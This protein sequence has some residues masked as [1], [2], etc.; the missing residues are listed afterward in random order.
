M[1]GSVPD[2]VGNEK[3][4]RISMLEV[5]E[6]IELFI[7]KNGSNPRATFM[8]TWKTLAAANSI[9]PFVFIAKWAGWYNN[10]QNFI[11]M[12]TSS[13]NESIFRYVLFEYATYLGQDLFGQDLFG[14]SV[15]ENLGI[16]MNLELEH[17]LPQSPPELNL[18][19][20]EFAIDPNEYGR[21]V[22]R[23]GNLTYL[24]SSC[25]GHL[26]NWTPDQKVA[27]YANCK[28][29]PVGQNIS[30]DII[31]TKKIGDDWSNLIGSNSE[32]KYAV[33][34]RCAELAN[35]CLQRFFW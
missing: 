33:Q 15:R 29:H 25:N 12:I 22:N 8:S 27:E 23:I 10:D 1:L 24:P 18:F 28:G 30:S 4:T 2:W 13:S 19:C 31:M 34:L 16:K 26:S 32:Y 11:S 9:K 17:I 3:P 14:N 5:I 6:K 21:F 20:A 7:W 35:F